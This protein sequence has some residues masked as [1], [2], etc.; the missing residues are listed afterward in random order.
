MTQEEIIRMAREACAF[1]KYE[2]YYFTVE[3]LERFANLVAEATK[4]INIEQAVRDDI[5]RQF[6]EL[7]KRDDHNDDLTIAYMVGFEAGKEATKEKAAKVCEGMPMSN[8]F[9]SD[10][11]AAIRSMK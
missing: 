2:I 1:E 7:K 9:Q 4:E 8:W 6:N 5:D 11:A 10:C 3:D